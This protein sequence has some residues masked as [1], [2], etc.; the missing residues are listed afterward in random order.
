MCSCLGRAPSLALILPRGAIAAIS[1]SLHCSL[2]AGA[3]RGTLSYDAPVTAWSNDLR[4][5]RRDLFE[6]AVGGNAAKNCIHSQLQVIFDQLSRLQASITGVASL[7]LAPRTNGFINSLSGGGGGGGL[8]HT[9]AA[10]LTT[11]GEGLLGQNSQGNTGGG[12]FRQSPRRRSARRSLDIWDWRKLV[13]GSWFGAGR[14][15]LVQQSAFCFR[16]AQSVWMQ[17]KRSGGRD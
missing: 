2:R 12:L 15:Q 3:E 5:G 16:W 7:G 8:T 4:S 17:R 14:E 6:G 9:G 11:Q 10:L 1:R 13:R